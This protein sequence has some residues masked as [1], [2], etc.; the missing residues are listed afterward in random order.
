VAVAVGLVVRGF[1]GYFLETA[2]QIG[3]LTIAASQIG[4]LSI[5]GF[6]VTGGTR[7]ALYILAGILVSLLGVRAA[8][9]V[10]DP[11]FDREAGL[12]P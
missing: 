7:L 9:V 4:A 5:A 1:A 3:G 11:S 10:E 2:G 6:D 12:E 8:S